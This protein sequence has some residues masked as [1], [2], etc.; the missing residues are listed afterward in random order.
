MLLVELFHNCLIVYYYKM[1]RRKRT[2]WVYQ[3]IRVDHDNETR[4]CTLCPADSGP[5]KVGP[6]GYIPNTSDFEYHLMKFHEEVAKVVKQKHLYHAVQEIR[7]KLIHS[8]IT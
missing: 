7:M 8:Y 4:Y 5:L 6:N 3:L 1:V 2:S